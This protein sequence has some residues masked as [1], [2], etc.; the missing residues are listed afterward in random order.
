MMSGITEIKVL[1]P[2]RIFS[3]TPGRF[4]AEIFRAHLNKN[5]AMLAP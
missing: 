4:A 5:V 1:F 3:L 2:A